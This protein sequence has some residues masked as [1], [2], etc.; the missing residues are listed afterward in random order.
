MAFMTRCSLFHS[1]VTMNRFLLLSSLLLLGGQRSSACPELCSCRGSQ[2]DCSSRS[3]TS[4]SM[5]TSFPPGTTEL[6]LHD[7][8]IT[9]LP[10]G[11][12]DGLSSLRS[13]S[14]QGNPWLCDCGVLYLRAWLRRHSANHAEHVGVNCSS[15]PNLKGRLVAYLTEEEVLE[16]CQYWY[17]NLAFTSFICLSVFVVAQVALLVT[18][19]IFLKRFERLSKEARRTNEEIFA[20]GESSRENEYE[21]LKDSSI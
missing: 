9:T 14:L 2:V 11:L 15:P 10:N 8:L 21:R 3:L 4:S 16:S 17:C 1:L 18:L 13:V 19:T 20:V 6:L 7:N 12:L 5:P